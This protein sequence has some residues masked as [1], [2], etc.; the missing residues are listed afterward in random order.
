MVEFV[1]ESTTSVDAQSGRKLITGLLDWQVSTRQHG[2]L[3]GSLN[4]QTVQP[5]VGEGVEDSV[6]SG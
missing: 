6:S 5:T 2:A 1:T 4:P 3:R